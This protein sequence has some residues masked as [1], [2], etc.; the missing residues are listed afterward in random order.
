[1]ESSVLANENFV[2][3]ILESTVTQQMQINKDRLLSQK[4]IESEQTTVSQKT[5]V[6]E[7][8]LDVYA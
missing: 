7:S 8:I 1:M 5:Q 3:Q 6:V 4:Q 2:R